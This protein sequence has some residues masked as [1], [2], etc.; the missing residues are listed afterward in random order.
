LHNSRIVAPVSDS[1]AVVCPSS[2]MT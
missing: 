1:L 2:P